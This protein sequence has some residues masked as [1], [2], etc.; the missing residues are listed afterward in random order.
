MP[1]LELHGIITVGSESLEDCAREEGQGQERTLGTGSRWWQSRLEGL[2][3][4]TPAAP[5]AFLTLRLEMERGGLVAPVSSLLAAFVLQTH[6]CL[7]AQAG[8][9]G[10]RHSIAHG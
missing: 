1:W 6:V 7:G 5:A 2:R 10:H 4:W 8:R 9:K 3:H